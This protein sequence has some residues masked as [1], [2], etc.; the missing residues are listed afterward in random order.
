MSVVAALRVKP[1]YDPSRAMSL[2]DHD[3]ESMRGAIDLLEER[4]PSLGHPVVDTIRDSRH[5]NM[6]ELR[7]IGGHLRALF[8]FEP[9]RRALIRLGG[10]KAGDWQ[11]FYRR[12]IPIADDLYDRYLEDMT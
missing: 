10:D 4:G 7:S 6:K 9:R 12:N 3:F 8:A 5:S 1:T 11:G 2:D